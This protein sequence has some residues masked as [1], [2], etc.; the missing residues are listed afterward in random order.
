MCG[1]VV[2]SVGWVL[3]FHRPSIFLFLLTVDSDVELSAPS[4][5]LSLPACYH[6]PHHDDNGVNL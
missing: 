4:L 5:A 2:G 1:L 6:V 3:R